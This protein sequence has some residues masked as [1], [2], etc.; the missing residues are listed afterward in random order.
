MVFT[1][2]AAIAEPATIAA[3]SIL[4]H[5]SLAL[6]AAGAGVLL[7]LAYLAADY[8]VVPALR[9]RA[10]RHLGPRAM[11]NLMDH[12]LKRLTCLRNTAAVQEEHGHPGAAALRDEAELRGLVVRVME[13]AARSP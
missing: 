12:E 9:L 7:A 6:P 2:E 5:W 1:L 11:K 10:A 3:G 8:L 13:H 4:E